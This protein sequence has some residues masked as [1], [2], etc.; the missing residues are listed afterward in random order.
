MKPAVEVVDETGLVPGEAS[1]ADLVAAVLG[2]EGASGAA[3]IAFVGEHVIVQLN[4]RYRGLEGSTD[5]LSFR[6]SDDETHW[7]DQ[8]GPDTVCVGGPFQRGTSPDLGEVIVCPQVVRRYA[9][10]EG[11]D[12][13]RQLVWTIIHGVLHLLGYDHERDEGEMR[14]REQALLEELGCL[15]SFVS[16]TDSG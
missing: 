12:P 10:E 6:Y 2:A 3:A 13:D 14:L 11:A 7:P 5:V 15:A 8:S 9:H 1:V 16:L 4:R